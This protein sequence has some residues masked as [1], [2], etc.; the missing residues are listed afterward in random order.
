VR[1]RFG[2]FTL[3][4][5]T[6][7]LLEDD[8]EIRLSPK[9]FDLLG[10]LLERRPGVVNKAE[11]HARIWPG[12]FVVDANLSVLINEIR[13]AVRDTPQDPRFIRTVHRV[14]YAFCGAA[15]DLGPPPASPVG[16]RCWL[17]WSDRTFVLSAGENVVGRDPRCDV[18]LDAPGVSRRHARI[19]IAEE[20]GRGEIEDLSSTNGTFLGG[21]RVVRARALADGDVI[22]IGAATLTFRAWSPDAARK[23]ERIRTPPARAK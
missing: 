2:R 17:A 23:T 3:D 4:S 16:S 11:L 10:M 14:G 7:Q 1:T 22:Q 12:T 13:R 8:R 20:N 5:A 18:W 19:Q 21:E 9:A 15:S 6:R